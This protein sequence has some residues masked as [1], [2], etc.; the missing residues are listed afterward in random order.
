MRAMRLTALAVLGSMV[1]L[2]TPGLATTT[3]TQS[4]SSGIA[5]PVTATTDM[6]SGGVALSG[7]TTYA[8]QGILSSTNGSSAVIPGGLSFSIT[9]SAATTSGETSGVLT[10]TLPAG[11][12]FATTPAA[13]LLSVSTSGSTS[14]ATGPIATGGVSAG[15]LSNGGNTLSFKLTSATQSVASTAVIQLGIFTITGA[16]S[17]LTPGNS[18]QL[19]AAVTGFVTNGT[20]AISLNDSRTLTGT[21]AISASGVTAS[22]AAG[23]GDT[24]AIS[25]NTIGT[26]FNSYDLAAASGAGTPTVIGQVADIGKVVLS[27]NAAALNPGT[28][29]AQYTSASK[30]TLTVTGTF[31]NY[32]GAYLSPTS[33]CT[34]TTPPSGA[35]SATMT[36]TALTFANVPLAGGLQAICLL[37]GGSAL[38]SPTGT[39]NA[40]FAIGGQAQTLSGLGTTGIVYAGT[41]FNLTYVFAKSGAYQGYLRLVNT[42]T[43][44]QPIFAIARNDSG[45]VV[46]GLLATLA[47]QSSQLIT[48]DAA[49]AAIGA[50]GAFPAGTRGVMTA[51]TPAPAIGASVAGV[52]TGNAAGVSVTSIVVNPTGDLTNLY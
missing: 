16:T 45:T 20:S 31:S 18:L 8:S 1:G 5:N 47:P 13:S 15:T 41:P 26:S 42:T 10:L 39:L 33:V 43:L 2:A 6:T 4:P 35:I 50:S 51:L 25:S 37:S 30:G 38:L 21:I 3:F 19:S 9:S 46:A 49:F 29:A 22:A 27:A 7:A 14:V 11:V 40:N 17:L 48:H 44:S 36:T 23:P 34:A 24:I 32:T 12:T 28:T 52:T